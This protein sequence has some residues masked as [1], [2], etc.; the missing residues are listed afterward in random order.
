MPD[1]EMS[2]SRRAS[3]AIEPVLTY[4]SRLSSKHSIRTTMHVNIAAYKFITLDKLEELRPQ[5]QALCNELGLKGT[6][7]LTPEGINMFVSGPRDSIDQ[8]LAWVRSDA[9]LADLQVKESLSNEQSHRRMLVRIKKEIITMRM[10][11]IQPE[12][13]RAPF[14]EAKTLKRWLDQGHDDAGKPVVMVDTRNDFEVDVGTFTDTVDYRI[15]KFT[16]FPDVIAAHK[17]DFAGKT[18][19]TFCTG[20]IR[21]EKAAIH[22]QNIGYD[23]VYQLEGGILKYFEDVGGEHYTGD[24]FVFDYRTALNPKLEP[25]ETVQCFA[26][27]AV[28][29]PRQQLD[30]AYVV[31]V[32]CPQCGGASSATSIA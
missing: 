25:T 29:T 28:V 11:L 31:G 30:P 27:R 26:C 17:D 12:L 6:V 7:L 4:N 10:P 2:T 20:G 14:V 3:N 13:G 22:M 24:C 8:Y 23:N 9:R 18:V 19:V 5:Y 16:E 15:K 21:C 32:S 1:L